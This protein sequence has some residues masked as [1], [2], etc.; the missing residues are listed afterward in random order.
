MSRKHNTKHGRSNSRYPDRLRA[1]SV[2]SR[3]VRMTDYV[4]VIHPDGLP[5]KPAS[6]AQRD[7][8]AQ[9]KRENEARANRPKVRT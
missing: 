2:S 8:V 4:P 1:R 3:D 5:S 6:S 9:I 7:A